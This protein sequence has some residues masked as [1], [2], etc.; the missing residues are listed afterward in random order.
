MEQH[1]MDLFPTYG[2]YVKPI[3]RKQEGFLEFFN[4]DKWHTYYN[5]FCFRKDKITGFI[6]LFTG[7]MGGEFIEILHCLRFPSYCMEI[8]DYEIISAH[9]IKF[10]FINRVTSK[11]IEYE[12]SVDP[13][14]ELLSATR[15]VEGELQPTSDVYLFFRIPKY[16][17]SR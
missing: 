15:S 13:D 14:D 12:L 17:Y 4:P 16:R 8:T 7:T 3:K 6:T 5:Y 2:V 10:S 1:N 11:K 9:E